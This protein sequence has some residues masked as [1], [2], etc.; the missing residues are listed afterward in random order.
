MKQLI[1]FLILLAGQG[2]VIAGWFIEW[3]GVLQGFGNGFCVATLIWW[4]VERNGDTKMQQA[5]AIALMLIHQVEGFRGT[6]GDN[7]NSW[8]EYQISQKCLDDV[9]RFSKC[10][11]TKADCYNP[12]YARRIA[13]IYLSHYG[14]EERLGHKPT[15]KDLCMIWNG[16]P[17]GHKEHCTLAYWYKA[18]MYLYLAIN[19]QK[20]RET[21]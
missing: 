20:E 2:C 6:D 14:T 1:M 13:S 10:N 16:G 18:R 3:R 12:V 8:G 19:K 17:D 21:A 9:N 5:I 7:G 4:G 15:A 11:Y